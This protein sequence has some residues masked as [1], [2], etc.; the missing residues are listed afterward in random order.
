LLIKL[1]YKSRMQTVVSLSGRL[2]YFTAED[3]G[4]AE[5]GAKSCEDRERAGERGLYV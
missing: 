3:V 2:G 5:E 4:A 1:I